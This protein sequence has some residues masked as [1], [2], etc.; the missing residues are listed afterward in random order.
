MC[1]A[2]QLDRPCPW[3]LPRTYLKLPEHCTSVP[4]VQATY[5]ALCL[6]YVPYCTACFLVWYDVATCCLSI[7][8]G[9][10]MEGTMLHSLTPAPALT[11]PRAQ[12]RR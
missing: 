8:S 12:R 1:N 9:L 7:E 6:V 10:R 4:T 11:H 3:K 2:V 5:I